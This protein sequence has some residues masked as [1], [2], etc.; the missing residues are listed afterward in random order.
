M[1]HRTAAGANWTS[2]QP[3]LIKPYWAKV[4]AVTAILPP[5][6]D[7]RL[8]LA[9]KIQLAQNVTAILTLNRA[10][11]GSKETLLMFWAEYSHSG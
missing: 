11:A 5:R 1:Q 10:L 9:F 7:W 2:L 3:L 4:L 6:I 8:C